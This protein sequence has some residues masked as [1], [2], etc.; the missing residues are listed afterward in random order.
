MGEVPR[1]LSE[2][3]PYGG[4][5]SATGGTLP[6]VAHAP[7]SPSSHS[8][9][10]DFRFLLIIENPP[11]SFAIF[12][13]RPERHLSRKTGFCGNDGAGA[14]APGLLQPPHHASGCFEN[15]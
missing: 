12:R 9:P 11:G 1:A 14:L 10:P 5:G 7:G 3:H 15:G 8:P 13:N 6:P 4:P 2:L